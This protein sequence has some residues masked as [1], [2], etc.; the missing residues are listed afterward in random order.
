[1]ANLNRSTLAADSVREECL[2]VKDCATQCSHDGRWH[3]HSD[4]VCP[5]HPDTIVEV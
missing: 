4:E 1:M 3:N 2:C 5:V